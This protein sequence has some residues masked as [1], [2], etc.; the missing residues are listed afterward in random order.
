MVIVTAKQGQSVDYYVSPNGSDSNP[1]SIDKPFQTVAHARDTIR[2]GG[3]LKKQPIT[4][5]LREGTYYLNDPLVFSAEDSGTPNAP[6]TYSA[7]K[8]EKVIISGG[9]KLALT[10]KPYRDG[11]LQAET[12][13]GL[14]IDQLFVNGKR[15]HMARYPNYDPNASP[16][17]GAA[18]DAFSPERAARWTGSY[19]WLHSRHA[20]ES[21]GRLPLPHYRQEAQ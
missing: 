6:V 21:L 20:Q 7:Y 18:A 16:Y 10:W 19:R 2:R 11:I 9:S 4:V 3:S 14:E 13:A 5:Y 1:G 12:P 8:G 17:N 15:Q